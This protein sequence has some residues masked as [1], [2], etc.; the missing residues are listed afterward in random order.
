MLLESSIENWKEVRTGLISEVSQIPAD[1][2]LFRARAETRSVTGILHHVLEAEQVLIGEVCRE[3]T[4][5]AR[6]PFTQLVA[7][8]AGDIPSLEGK[9]NLLERLTNNFKLT[10]ERLR[11]F[12]EEA[13]QKEMRRL[14]GRV[15]PKLAFL[16]F[17]IN[18]EMYHRGQITVYERLLYIEPAITVR[19]NEFLKTKS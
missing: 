7:E 11:S 15:M 1:Q 16:N 4:D 6:L 2:F 5:F 8:Y 10:E 18:H 14:D 13:M 19:V 9:E 17:V 12:G 3:D